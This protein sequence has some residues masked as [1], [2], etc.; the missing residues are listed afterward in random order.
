MEATRR[1]EVSDEMPATKV[2]LQALPQDR[3]TGFQQA[4]DKELVR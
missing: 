3:A 2:S 4:M 1:R